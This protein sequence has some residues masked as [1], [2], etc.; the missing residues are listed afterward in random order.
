VIDNSRKKGIP[1]LSQI[2]S[3][4]MQSLFRI[5]LILSLIAVNVANAA[6]VEMAAPSGLNLVIVEGEGAINNVRQRTAR[7]PIVQVEDENHKPVAGAAVLFVLPDGGP[8]GAFSNGSRTLQV[9]TD[10]QG[11]AAA[12][13]LRA[14]NIS[15]KYQIRVEA[16]YQGMRA[17]TVINQTNAVMAAAAAG[18]GR[19]FPVKLVAILGGIGGAVAAGVLIAK[20]GGNNPTTI[21]PGTPSVGGP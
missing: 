20:R 5:G 4:P 15:G 9:V 18:G 21:T 3:G 11:R 17:A 13:G 14:N 16:S 10:N 1:M 12:K 8:G 2:S 7:E 6:P 19:A